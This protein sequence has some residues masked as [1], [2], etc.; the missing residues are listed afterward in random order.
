MKTLLLVLPFA[1]GL[2]AASAAD[3]VLPEFNAKTAGHPPLSLAEIAKVR[4]TTPPRSFGLIEPRPAMPA[5]TASR[6]RVTR[7][8]GMPIVRPDPGVEHKI[9]VKAPDPSVDYKMIVQAPDT[10]AASEPGK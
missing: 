1:F 2:S 9:A 3:A 6:P 10:P 4:A 5:P 7:Q 8:S